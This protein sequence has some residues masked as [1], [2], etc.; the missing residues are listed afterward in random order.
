MPRSGKRSPYIS[1]YLQVFSHT[2]TVLCLWG[3]EG[4]ANRTIE[5]SGS[6]KHNKV[7]I[8]SMFYTPYQK[9]PHLVSKGGGPD[10]NS[11]GETVGPSNH[12]IPFLFKNGSNHSQRSFPI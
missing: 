4:Q 1:H 11:R 8:D 5:F 9:P 3:E 12:L 10:R 7:G 2:H 6:N